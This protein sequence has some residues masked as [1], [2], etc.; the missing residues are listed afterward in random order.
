VCDTTPAHCFPVNIGTRDMS[1]KSQPCSFCT[2][3][4]NVFFIKYRLIRILK[5]NNNNFVLPILFRR[6]QPRPDNLPPRHRCSGGRV[7]RRRVTAN[8]RGCVRILIYY[9]YIG[10]W[11]RFTDYVCKYLYNIMCNIYMYTKYIDAYVCV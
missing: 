6:Q 11:H 3:G 2:P 8:G 1:L 4:V 10:Y 9:M 5:Y 7:C